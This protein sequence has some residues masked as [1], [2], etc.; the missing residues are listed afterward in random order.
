[1]CIRDRSLV[2]SP[3]AIRIDSIDSGGM[4]C[5]RSINSLAGSPGIIRGI[6]KFNVIATKRANNNK[7]ILRKK[8]FTISPY[9]A[10]DAQL[11]EDRD[12]PEGRLYALSF[13]CALAQM[14]LQQ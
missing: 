6:K 2:S 5:I 12:A 1:M 10:F 11:F 4:P 13:E 8:Y 7:P 9:P 14:N 3:K